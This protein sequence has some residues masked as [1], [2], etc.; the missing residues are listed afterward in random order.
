MNPE[1]PL[2]LELATMLSNTMS[3][4]E[5]DDLKIAWSKEQATMLNALGPMR[6][7]FFIVMFAISISLVDLPVIV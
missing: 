3:L 7:I 4:M 6:L 5:I 2:E 1:V